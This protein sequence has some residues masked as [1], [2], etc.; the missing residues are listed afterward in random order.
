MTAC[1]TT[2]SLKSPS[3]PPT[4][5]TMPSGPATAIVALA[6]ERYVVLP[7]P[8]VGMAWLRKLVMKVGPAMRATGCGRASRCVV[9]GRP[10]MPSAVCAPAPRRLESGGDG[11]TAAGQE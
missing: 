6:T 11:T 5:G 1:R 7:A 3:S 9:Q 2:W 8:P 4:G 10:W